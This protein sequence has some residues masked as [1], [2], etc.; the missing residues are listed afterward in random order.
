MKRGFTLVEILITFLTLGLLFGLLSYT[1]YSSIRASLDITEEGESL[2]QD[3]LLLWNIQRKII[4]SK[5]IVLDKDNIFMTTSAGD[6]HEGV[7]KC[8]FIYKKPLLYYYEFPYPYGN[9][10]FYEEDKLI[11]LG[12][13]ENFTIRAYKNGNFYKNFIG[14]PELFYVSVNN[15]ELIVKPFY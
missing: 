6:Y 15:K 7:V 1:F 2:K 11:R 3:I 10:E 5:Y 8:A 9:I 4:S 12:K 13:F 14:I